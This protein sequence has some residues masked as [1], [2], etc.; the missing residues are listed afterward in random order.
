MGLLSH[1]RQ[2]QITNAT[3][4]LARHSRIFEHYFEWLDEQPDPSQE[5]RTVSLIARSPSSPVALAAMESADE[6]KAR[7]VAVKA[8]VSQ[9]EPAQALRG[10]AQALVMLTDV[11]DVRELAR[12]ANKACLLDAHEQLILGGS[13][14]WSG[15]VMRREPGKC[16]GL[17]LFEPNA[18]QT[19]RLGVLAF[20]AIW[21]VCDS[22]PLAAVRGVLATRPNASGSHPNDQALAAFSFMNRTDR[23]TATRH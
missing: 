13:M 22:L 10:L 6:L 11:K 23:L 21:E 9:T 15:D 18:P 3:T 16:D 20:D 8:I 4:A 19:V 7:G 12:W 17:D 14:C 2:T 1:L 5:D